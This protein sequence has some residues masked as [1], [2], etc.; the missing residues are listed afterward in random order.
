MKNGLYAVSFI[1]NQQDNGGGVI[2]IRDGALN[3]G[4][5]GYT[6]QGTIKEGKTTLQVKQHDNQVISVFEITGDFDV[7]LDFRDTEEGF[8]AEG[9]VQGEQELAIKIRGKYIS[10][11]V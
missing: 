5:T 9:N 6:Y 1:S 10:A 8:E 7:D 11:L 2:S 4:D 3:G